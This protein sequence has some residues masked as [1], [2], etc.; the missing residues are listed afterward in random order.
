M[1]HE[2]KVGRREAILVMSKRL[3]VR[4]SEIGGVISAAFGEVYGHLG[5]RGVEPDGPPFVIYHG[6]PE[7]DAPF[8]VEICAPTTRAT[9]PPAGWQVQELPAGTFATLVHVGPYDTLGTAY[10]TLTAWIG[11]HELAIA[12]P[13]RE[14]YLSEPETPPEQVKT[15]VEFPVSEVA[16]P[17]AA[18]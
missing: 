5:R 1:G 2:V 15:I 14:V 16:T 13:P 10:G 12:G 7:S 3:P 8:D 17:V 6:M 18:G 4:L 11:A 9:D